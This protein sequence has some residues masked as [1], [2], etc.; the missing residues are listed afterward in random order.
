M[1]RARLAIVAAVLVI[2]SVSGVVIA[3]SAPAVPAPAVVT[4]PPSAALLLAELQTGGASAS[5]EFVEVTN[6][7]PTTV[8]LAGLEVVYVTSTGGTVTRKASWSAA[9]PLDPGRHLLIANTSGIYAAI[10]D[11]T[12]SGGFAAKTPAE[13]AMSTC[14]P[15][16]R[17]VAVV[18]DAFLVTV[19]PVEVA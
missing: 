6:A 1:E 15:G 3:A 14:R 17:M 12:Y 10:A 2:L 18:H 16:S 13:L 9:R 11:A 5:D 7:G 8:D 19:L 4:W